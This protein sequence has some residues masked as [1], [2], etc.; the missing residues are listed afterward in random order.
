[1]SRARVHRNLKT[2]FNELEMS[3]P[4]PWGFTQEREKIPDLQPQ[5]VLRIQPW[6][7]GYTFIILHP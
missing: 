2:G 7:I 1:M 4:E 3:G 6:I 5:G